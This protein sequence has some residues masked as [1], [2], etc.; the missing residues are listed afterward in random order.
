MYCYCSTVFINQVSEIPLKLIAYDGGQPP[1]SGHINIR[2][3][4]LD[5]NDNVPVFQSDRSG[6]E[7]SNVTT[8]APP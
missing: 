3:R 1:Q 5:S 4:I 2:V 7:V 6:Y 8:T